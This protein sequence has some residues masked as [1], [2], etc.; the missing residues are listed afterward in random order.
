[1][2]HQW[3]GEAGQRNGHATSRLER[4]T[5]A[6]VVYSTTASGYL[7]RGHRHAEGDRGSIDVI[8]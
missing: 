2:K 1:M 5:Q 3:L 4:L 6:S 7:H 8:I